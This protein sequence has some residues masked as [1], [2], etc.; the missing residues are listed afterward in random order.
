MISKKHHNRAD[1][2][3]DQTPDVETGYTFRAEHAAEQNSSASRPRCR[4][5]C[6]PH[7]LAALVYDLATNKAR[8]EAQDEP[9]D[10]SHLVSL[11]RVLGLRQWQALKD[12]VSAL[13][14]LPPQRGTYFLFGEK[15]WRD[16]AD[17]ELSPPKLHSVLNVTSALLCLAIDLAEVVFSAAIVLAS[18]AAGENS[19]LTQPIGGCGRH[20]FNSP[21]GASPHPELGCLNGDHV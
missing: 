6:Q 21:R 14:S 19:E 9:T 13:L 16:Y 2:R 18:F 11:L 20:R 12:P 7:T 8:N 5:Q 10:N 3:D 17:F 15:P 1:D 4:G